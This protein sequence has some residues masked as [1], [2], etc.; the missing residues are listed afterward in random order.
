MG[1]YFTSLKSEGFHNDLSEADIINLLDVLQHCSC[2]KVNRV[3]VDSLEN[4]SVA[5]KLFKRLPNPTIFVRQWVKIRCKLIKDGDVVDSA[6]TLYCLLSSSSKV[7]R[8]TVGLLLEQELMVYEEMNSNFSWRMQ[9][10]SNVTIDEVK[11]MALDMISNVLVSIS[12]TCWT[13]LLV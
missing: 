6:P 2:H 3:I 5:V 1:F 8:S 7:E 12:F 13:P 10:K 4:W 9:M 11:E